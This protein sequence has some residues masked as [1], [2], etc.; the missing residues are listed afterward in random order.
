MSSL[1]I[2]DT[3]DEMISELSL[4]SN[5][6]LVELR[7]VQLSN[8]MSNSQMLASWRRQR[9][10]ISA[11]PLFAADDMLSGN[12]LSTSLWDLHPLIC[13]FVGKYF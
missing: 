7:G 4:Q 9:A 10:W 2:H 1:S 11:A 5:P 3:Q 8:G 12:P 13:E 6:S